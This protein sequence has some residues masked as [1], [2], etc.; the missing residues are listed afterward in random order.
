VLS[1][2]CK[3]PWFLRGIAITR[4]RGEAARFLNRGQQGCFRRAANPARSVLH[5]PTRLLTPSDSRSPNIHLC[6]D[7]L[8]DI[9]IIG[10]APSRRPNRPTG[11]VPR[12]C[13]AV[14]NLSFQ[15]FPASKIHYAHSRVRPYSFR[16]FHAPWLTPGE[17]KPP[18]G[19]GRKATPLRG[20]SNGREDT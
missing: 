1:G 14:R 5:D 2:N 20:P 19:G 4:A 9:L 12:Q 15:I 8:A 17:G 18:E 3:L 6:R 10:H 7:V 11:T 13:P 16:S